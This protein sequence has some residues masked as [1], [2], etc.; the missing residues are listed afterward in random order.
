[1]IFA[2]IQTTIW[3]GLAIFGFFGGLVFYGGLLLLGALGRTMHKSYE[4]GGGTPQL[5]KNI[6][7]RLLGMLL[8]RFIF[9]R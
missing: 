7:V 6:L 1:M 3:L 5:G 2:D 4:K 8:K 9:K